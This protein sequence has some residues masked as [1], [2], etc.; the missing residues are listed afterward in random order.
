M[1]L[2]IDC[3]REVKNNNCTY[4][5]DL[6]L[7]SIFTILYTRLGQ[8]QVKEVI[9]LNWDVQFNLKAIKSGNDFLYV[10]KIAIHYGC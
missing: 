2:Y 9:E 4:H 10:G 7:L 8:Y 1:Y 5:P 3:G 6:C